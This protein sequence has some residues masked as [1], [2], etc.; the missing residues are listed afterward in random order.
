MQPT[1]LHTAALSGTLADVTKFLDPSPTPEEKKAAMKAKLAEFDKWNATPLHMAVQNGNAEEKEKI[2]RYLVENGAD[3]N[4]KNGSDRTP[5]QVASLAGD[6]PTV[7]LLLNLGAVVP[8]RE[9]ESKAEAMKA[10]EDMANGNVKLF[11]EKRRT[12][13]DVSSLNKIAEAKRWPEDVEG[14]IRGNLQR[15]DP[16]QPKGGKRKTRARKT[17]AR[18]PKRRITRRR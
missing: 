18:K 1:T 6:L 10:L 2:I 11:F 12:G 8:R 5:L 3:L 17:R 7:Q 13:K 16:K 15:E 4:A 9:N 14:V